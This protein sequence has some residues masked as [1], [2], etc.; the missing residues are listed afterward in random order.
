[1]Q[2]PKRNAR[3]LLALAAWALQACGSYTTTDA[4]AQ[5]VGVEVHPAAAEVAPGGKA[6]FAAVVTGTADL[7]VVWQVVEAGGGAVDAAGL[8]TAP[9]GGGTFHVRASSHVDLTAQGTATVTVKPPVAVAVAISPASASVAA[10]GTVSFT[11][12]VTGATDTSVTW[13]VAET[14]ACGTVTQGGVYTAPPVAATCHVVATSHADPSKSATATVGVSAPPPPV[15]VSVSP[16]TGSVHSCQTLTFRATVTGATDT[17]VSWAVQEGAAGGT[18]STSGAYTAPNTAGTYH[19]VA[20]SRADPTKSAIAQVQVTDL[21]LGVAVS[22]STITVA[23]GG[24]AQFTA[25]VTTT[26]GAFTSTQTIAA[27]DLASEN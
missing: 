18:I 7:G 21:V 6:G 24:T 1:M 12:A 16:S 22:P 14:T 26:C 4:A 17:S 10:G 2:T 8:Y 19:V 25:T 15:T 5:R 11:A 13:S 20:T 9:A 3:S 23:A 27:A